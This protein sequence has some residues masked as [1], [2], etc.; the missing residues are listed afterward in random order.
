MIRNNFSSILK[1]VSRMSGGGNKFSHFSE[2]APP[3]PPYAPAAPGVIGS[4]QE[5][6]PT[7]LQ[8]CNMEQDDSIHVDRVVN[9]A[10][11]KYYA[12]TRSKSDARWC[13]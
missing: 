8:T 2:F 4:Y 3:T 7:L 11:Y 1:I 6:V 10:S 9:A 13:K 12:R 5:L